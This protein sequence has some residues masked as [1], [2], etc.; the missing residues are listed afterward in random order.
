M[1]IEPKSDIVHV[2]GRTPPPSMQSLKNN[3]HFLSFELLDLLI[4]HFHSLP[5]EIEV[6]KLSWR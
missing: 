2:S 6:S 3:N 5:C 4:F 1:H